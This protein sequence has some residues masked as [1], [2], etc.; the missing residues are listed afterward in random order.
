MKN[1]TLLLLLLLCFVCTS[2]S[3]QI[4]ATT[5]NGEKVLLMTD[6]SW[7][8]RQVD[9]VEVAPGCD[10][11][12]EVTDGVTGKTAVSGHTVNA[13]DGVDGIV[14]APLFVSNIVVLTIMSVDNGQTVCISEDQPV[15]FL[16]TDGTRLEMKNR[17]DF[18]C[19]GV[20]SVFLAK[21]MGTKKEL[22]Q[23]ATKTIKTI[24]V[25]NR[26]SH[27]QSTLPDDEANKLMV[28]IYCLL[29]R[30]D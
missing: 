19:K 6:G 10:L 8:Y 27:V 15:Y 5:N 23:L 2:V 28:S 17:S 16:F 1:P 3:A 14:I 24:R 11:I 29:E 13:T 20:A 18:N 25:S 22:D 7:K 9:T 26:N 4:E 21:S 12:K 30:M